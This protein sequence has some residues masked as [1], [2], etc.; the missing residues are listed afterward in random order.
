MKKI[1]NVV[2]NKFFLVSVAF[3]AWMLFFDSNDFISQYE[4]R[5]EVAKLRSEK[6]FY[7]HETKLVKRDL[8]ELNT[9][10]ATMEKF[11]REKYLMKKPNE[12]IFVIVEEPKKEKKKRFFF[13]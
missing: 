7:A 10:P 4:Y 11:A 9:K 5:T 13:F 2:S 8:L 1:F 6:D 12:E 3:L